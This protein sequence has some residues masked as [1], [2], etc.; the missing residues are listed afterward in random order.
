MK[1]INENNKEYFVSLWLPFLISLGL[2]IVQSTEINIHQLIF[3]VDCI[4]FMDT[5]TV[6]IYA[7]IVPVRMIS[8]IEN[9]PKLYQFI[10]WFVGIGLYILY[11]FTQV[12]YNIIFLFISLCLG[13]ISYYVLRKHL[14][15][16]VRN[17]N[18]QK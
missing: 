8:F 10:L 2:S 15:K 6:C 9:I 13:V 14:I 12:S 3:N 11:S 5:F 7:T 18:K 17:E 16:G 1:E 4:Q